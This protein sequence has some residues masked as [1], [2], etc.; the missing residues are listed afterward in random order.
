LEKALVALVPGSAF[1][2]P[3]CLRI[4]YATSENN[5]IRA[6]Q[7]IKEALTVLH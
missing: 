4:S 7:R 6:V 3:N 5:L 2:D 1:G